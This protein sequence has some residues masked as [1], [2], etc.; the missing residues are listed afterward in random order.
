MAANIVEASNR[1]VFTV[2]DYHGISTHLEREIIPW[3]RNLARVSSEKP[4]AAPD[5]LQVGAIDGVFRVE[6]TWQ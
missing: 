6:L 5:V 2:D 3:L 4:T 1:T